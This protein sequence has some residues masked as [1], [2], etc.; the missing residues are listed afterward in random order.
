MKEYIGVHKLTVPIKGYEVDM[1]AVAEFIVREQRLNQ[2]A[3][4]LLNLMVKIDGRPF[5]GNIFSFPFF[6]VYRKWTNTC[7]IIF[8]AGAWWNVLHSNHVILFNKTDSNLQLSDTLDGNQ[9]QP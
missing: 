6:T 3:E 1:F 9:T 4:P 7:I 2:I 5:W 8:F